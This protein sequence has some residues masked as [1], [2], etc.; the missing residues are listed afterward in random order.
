MKNVKIIDNKT[1]RIDKNAQLI[2][3]NN[4]KII[5]IKNCIIEEN[6]IIIADKSDCIITES[7]I[8]SNVRI[9][10]SEIESVYAFPGSQIL[11]TNIFVK[12]E[13]NDNDNDN[14]N[15]YLI[16]LNQGLSFDENNFALSRGAVIKRIN[17]LNISNKIEIPSGHSLINKEEFM[18][19]NV[20][21]IKNMKIYE[22]IEGNN[23]IINS[24]YSHF[25]EYEQF[26]DPMD[27]STY[28]YKD[29]IEDE[30]NDFFIFDL[31]ILDKEKAKTDSYELGK[32]KAIYNESKKH[33]KLMF[34]NTE[35]GITI[36]RK[37]FST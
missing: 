37:E 11:E 31:R 15:K 7:Y 22:E 24:Q 25:E 3:K 28:K 8:S 34:L 17:K 36:I 9:R 35:N 16:V 5:F 1:V 18:K 20:K 14:N 29:R 12:T 30:L 21:I 23:Y 27:Y 19:I 2:T 4:K 32:I 13:E 6:A 33:E 10:N 26:Y